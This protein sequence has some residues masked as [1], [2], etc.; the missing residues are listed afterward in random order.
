MV[1]IY[2]FSIHIFH[3][4]VRFGITHLFPKYWARLSLFQ[5]SVLDTITTSPDFTVTSHSLAS[6]ANRE[7]IYT[8]TIIYASVWFSLYCKPTFIYQYMKEDFL[9]FLRFTLSLLNIFYPFSGFLNSD[10]FYRLYPKYKLRR[11][12]LVMVNHKNKLVANESWFTLSSQL[13]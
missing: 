10:Y 9:R 11:T 2:T 1:C 3:S 8:V 7:E 13:Y 4:D 6:H 12:S 5:S